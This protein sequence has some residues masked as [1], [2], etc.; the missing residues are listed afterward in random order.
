M[1]LEVS[2]AL[3]QRLRIVLH[4]F[5]CWALLPELILEL[6]VAELVTEGDVAW[7]AKRAWAAARVSDP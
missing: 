4:K 7:A 3:E 6:W 2:R 1:S 5:E